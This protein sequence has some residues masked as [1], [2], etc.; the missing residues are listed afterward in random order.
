[1][2]SLTTFPITLLTLLL[3]LTPG[4]MGLRLF[5][6]ASKRKSSLT[7]TR[8]IVYSSVLSG[9]SVFVLYVISHLLL[10]SFVPLTEGLADSLNIVSGSDLEAISLPGAVG[11]Y[12]T[13][14]T[15]TVFLGTVI[16]RG[17]RACKFRYHNELLD[18]REPW[19]FI[20]TKSPRDGEW[21]EVTLSGGD[22]IQGRFN[23]RA[24]DAEER[25]LFLDDPHRVEY[26]GQEPQDKR[27]DLG[28]SIYLH[29]DAIQQVVTLE[30]DPNSDATEY[31]A[32]IE[33][34]RDLRKDIEES[35]ENIEMEMSIDD[36]GETIEDVND[37]ENVNDEK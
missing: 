16:G 1:M 15:L 12:L 2:A 27:E 34:P 4:L 5:Y 22:I 20:F 3:L 31:M 19:E 9:V 21:V 7:R 6:E 8:L 25:E 29:P 35:I 30:D 33:I 37:D 11:L 36:F 14:I 18:R 17:Y 23:K 28:R 10:N 32:E 24:F 13:H 26:S